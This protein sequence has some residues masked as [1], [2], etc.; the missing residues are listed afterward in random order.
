MEYYSNYSFQIEDVKIRVTMVSYRKFRQI[1]PMHC[2]GENIYEIHYVAGGRGTVILDSVSYGIEEGTLYV[3]G[4]NVFHEQI[5]EKDNPVTEF[6]LYLHVDSPHPQGTI[7]S[8]FCKEVRWVGRGRKELRHFMQQIILEHKRKDLGWEK[9]IPFLLA[10]FLIDCVRS[11]GSSLPQTDELPQPDETFF[12]HEIR[13]ENAQLVMDEM[14]LYE[15]REICLEGLAERLGFSVRQTQR[16]IRK[17]YHKSFSEKK[18]E[19]RMLAAVTM[20]SHTKMKITD[21]SDNLGYSSV[22][23]F[24]HAFSQYYGKSPREFRK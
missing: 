19:A 2:H 14:F 1:L 6:G 4:P 15:Y 24:S 23:H 5:P 17:I 13:E 11:Y 18:R 9:K 10:E 21:I 12:T 22:E 16:F 20:L 3:T 7:M 8:A